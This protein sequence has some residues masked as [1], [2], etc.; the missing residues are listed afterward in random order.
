MGGTS[1][2]RAVSLSTGK[3]IAEALD[4]N[5]YRIATI[6]TRDMLALTANVAAQLPPTTAPT[7]DSVSLLP[8][9]TK[10]LSLEAAEPEKEDSGRPDVVFI[11]LHGKGGED[12]TIQGALELMGIPYT[13]SGVLASALAMNKRM[14]KQI[15]RLHSIPVIEDLSLQRGQ[16]PSDAALLAMAQEQFG[17]SAL[18]V[19]PSAEGS[20]FGCSLVERREELPSA[21]AFALKYDS[22]I[23]VERYI[24]GKEITAGVLEDPT[25]PSGLLALPLIEIIPKNA[26]YDYESKYAPDGSEHIIPARLSK[27]QTQQAQEIA[28]LCHTVLGCK[29]MSRTDLIATED[30]LYVLEVNT[31]PGMTPTSL[32]PQA[33]EHAGISFPELLDRLIASALGQGTT[34]LFEEGE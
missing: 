27:A 2:E 11:A 21:V 10:S 9:E 22:H 19:K 34:A 30:A 13:G 26:Y 17:D 8:L 32:L 18:F 31:I 16:V 28:R 7:T 15:F 12:G 3:M 5:H 23:L 6:D 20:T 1:N 4:K 25:Q 29:G 14:A 24:K 33:A